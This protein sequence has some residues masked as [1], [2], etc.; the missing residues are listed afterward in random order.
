MH[1]LFTIT[2]LCF[3][4]YIWAPTV[5]LSQAY[6]ST[7]TIFTSLE[8]A[9]LQPENV[10]HLRLRKKRLDSLPKEIYQLQNLRILDLSKN[11]LKEIYGKEYYDNGRW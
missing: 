2:A 4:F 7:K 1:S 6:D 5:G 8:T 9:L 11:K 3:C 10:Y